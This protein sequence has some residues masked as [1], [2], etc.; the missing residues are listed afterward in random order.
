MEKITKIT[1]SG[2]TIGDIRPALMFL[3]TQRNDASVSF[4]D[5]HGKEY[6]AYADQVYALAW[7]LTR[8]DD[9]EIIEDMKYDQ[10]ALSL[11]I[12]ERDGVKH[13]DYYC[14]GLDITLDDCTDLSWYPSEYIYKEVGGEWVREIDTED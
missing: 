2:I 9:D 12:F 8:K 11:A 14:D 7:A 5:Y 4:T 1:D 3:M 6:V 13:Y 10:S